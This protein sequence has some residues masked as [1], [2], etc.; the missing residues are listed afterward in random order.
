LANQRSPNG[1]IGFVVLVDE[2]TNAV[3]GGLRGIAGKARG[4]G[5]GGLD[6]LGMGGSNPVDRALFP[7]Q[8]GGGVIA[9][10]TSGNHRP[11][12]IHTLPQDTPVWR[13][14]T[15]ERLVR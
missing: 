14:A 5:A 9:A 15:A 11:P 13:P 1:G 7:R 10:D 2:I 12:G 4:G 6:V 3:L 8:I